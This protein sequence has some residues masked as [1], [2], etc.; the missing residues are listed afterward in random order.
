MLQ[1]FFEIL[2]TNDTVF[3]SIVVLLVVIVVIIEFCDWWQ[4]LNN[5]NSRINCKCSRC[6]GPA[7]YLTIGD[8]C[9]ECAWKEVMKR[10]LS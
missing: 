8:I 7:N 2:D 3:F 1:Q 10:G 4:K 6:N 9:Q 5:N